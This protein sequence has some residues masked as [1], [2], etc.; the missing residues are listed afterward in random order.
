MD[1]FRINDNQSGAST[2]TLKRLTSTPPMTKAQHQSIR[3]AQVKQR[4]FVEDLRQASAER[5]EIF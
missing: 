4:R 2:A 3:N 5:A 1:N